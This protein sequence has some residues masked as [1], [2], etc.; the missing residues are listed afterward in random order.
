MCWKNVIFIGLVSNL[1]PNVGLIHGTNTTHIFTI[2]LVYETYNHVKPT[3][4]IIIEIALITSF[5]LEI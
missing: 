1:N 5:V 3:L 2:I 4:V